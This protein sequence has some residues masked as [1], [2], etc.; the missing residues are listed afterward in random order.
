MLAQPIENFESTRR[1]ARLRLAT[2]LRNGELAL[3]LG[4][5][6]QGAQ[7]AMLVADARTVTAD[8]VNKMT[9]IGCSVVCCAV[10]D[11][12]AM[13][14]GLELIAPMRPDGIAYCRSVEAATGVSTGISAA[15]RALTLNVIASH[16]PAPDML[17]KPGHIM[18]NLV[19]PDLAAASVLPDAVLPAL[20]TLAPVLAAA[21]CYLLDENGN[22]ANHCQALAIADRAGIPAFSR[23]RAY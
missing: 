12:R 14:L 8:A 16:F 5:D 13:R 10:D 4:V 18:P 20:S 2:A 1:T 19:D 17:V 9:M 3:L 23:D 22:V 6:R 7:C 11:R 21:W 15:D